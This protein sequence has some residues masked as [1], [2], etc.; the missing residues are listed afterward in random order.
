MQNANGEQG[1]DDAG[2]AQQAANQN[3]E[4]TDIVAVV[5]TSESEYNPF[6]AFNITEP[7]TYC[8]LWSLDL[9]NSCNDGNCQCTYTEVLVSENRLTCS[10]AWDCPSDSYGLPAEEGDECKPVWLA[11]VNESDPMQVQ[12]TPVP[13]GKQK[14][15]ETAMLVVVPRPAS[16]KQDKGSLFPDI[17]EDEDGK[18]AATSDSAKDT[19]GN[20]THHMNVDEFTPG[21]WLVPLS[22]ESVASSISE[23]DDEDDLSIGFALDDNE[24]EA[25]SSSSSN[26]SSDS[27]QSSEPSLQEE[28]SDKE[29]SCDNENAVPEEFVPKEQVMEPPKPE[30]RLRD[31]NSFSSSKASTISTTEEDLEPEESEELT[32]GSD[33][34]EI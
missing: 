11:P 20:D 33:M 10:E 21:L 25:H 8:N 15:Q 14:R 4:Q 17:L 9:L 1:N 34:A 29:Q 23:S 19:G 6:D 28:G 32:V 13:V 30:Y 31:D 22:Q 7:D 27:N 12:S 3:G 26:N 16:E 18:D 24:E 2:Q 5:S